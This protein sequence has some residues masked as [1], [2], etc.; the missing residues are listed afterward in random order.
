MRCLAIVAG[1]FLLG[2]LATGKPEDLTADQE[3][4]KT[5]K[6]GRDGP[7][8]LKLFRSRTMTPA[9][10]VDIQA[11]IRQLGD[12]VFA[13]RQK[14]SV[15]LVAKGA[16]ALPLLREA[17]RDSDI[18][19]GRRASACARR[20]EERDYDASVLAAAA[21]L[22]GAAKPQGTAEVL[23][24]YLPF[25]NDEVIED[26]IRMAL[27]AAAVQGGKPDPVLIAALAD[28]VAI[29]RGAAGAALASVVDQRTAVRKLLK[30]P[31]PM[32][33]LRAGIGLARAR[34]KDAISVLIELLAVLPR[35]HGWL[36]EDI[37]LRLAGEQAPPV[38]LGDEPTERKKC[39]DA[40]AAW[41]ESQRPKV[42][43]AK[44]GNDAA[45]LGYT[46]VIVFNW[47][48]NHRVTELDAAGKPRWI[49]PN[50]PNPVD[51]HILPGNRVLIA[52]YSENRVT[53]RNFKGD[54]LWE[55]SVSGPINA[56]RLPNGNTFIA[57]MNSIMEVDRNGKEI[58]NKNM[59]VWAARK[60]PNGQIA[61]VTREKQ[62]IRLDAN[63]KELHKVP[64]TVGIANSI[65]GVDFLPNGRV[66]TSLTDSVAEYDLKG[67]I[68]WKA[69]VPRPDGVTRLANGNTLVAC[70][71]SRE[72]LELDRQG[73]TIRTFKL[74]G[75]GWLARRR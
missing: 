29:K 49:I 72:V 33:R 59:S 70:T 60:Y 68:V 54:V 6:V 58:I 1:C 23:L 30:D 47:G 32:V 65:G 3:I 35:E 71:G 39:R 38:S 53:E 22:L 31:E 52:D 67:N 14:A 13:V 74:E 21:R 2:G 56:Q 45:L 11:L 19:V 50:L 64:V 40:W 18:E 9:L 66:L 73:K 55:K 36:A 63:G 28:P 12:K 4:L 7:S 34:V 8:L 20:I 41:W 37:L 42:D 26:E 75:G 62:F 16:V 24:G 17:V 69:K 61:L 10:R 57:T 51:A 27:A 25:A 46:L 15:A 5:A 48:G 43:F 44:L